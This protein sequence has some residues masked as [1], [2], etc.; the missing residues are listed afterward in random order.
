MTSTTK[1]DKLDAASHVLDRMAARL[2][3]VAR[4]WRQEADYMRNGDRSLLG[5][6]PGCEKRYADAASRSLLRGLA[7][8]VDGITRAVQSEIP[9]A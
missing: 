5:T 7:Q 3:I 6:L 2:E 1:T 4:A 8:E 9:P